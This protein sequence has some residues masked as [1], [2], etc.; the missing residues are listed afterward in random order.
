MT[1][2][3][4]GHGTLLEDSDPPARLLYGEKREDYRRPIRPVERPLLQAGRGC[5]DPLS[6]AADSSSWSAAG[7]RQ[8]SSSRRR[9][10]LR[11]GRATAFR[12]ENDA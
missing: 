11:R 6:E 5:P 2:L 7:R 8:G 9:G 1:A 4:L 12:P 3:S 10:D